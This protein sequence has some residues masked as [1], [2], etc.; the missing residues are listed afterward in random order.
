L[1]SK[2]IKIK[3]PAQSFFISQVAPIINF[4]GVF[5][6]LINPNNQ[7]N[8]PAPAIH[9]IMFPKNPWAFNPKRENA[10][11]P[12]IPPIKPI[13]ILSIIPKPLPLKK[14]PANQPE[15]PPIDRH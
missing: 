1:A 11:L 13:K 9:V 3:T 2:I 12:I 5:Y 7:N 6:I 15:R 14:I 8:I 4:I 10:K